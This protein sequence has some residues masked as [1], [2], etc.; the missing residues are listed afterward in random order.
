M[1]S[2]LFR[3][4]C[5]ERPLVSLQVLKGIQTVFFAVVLLLANIL[6]IGSLVTDL[7]IFG[8]SPY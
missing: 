3:K 4:L 6:S 5:L 8:L 2:T 7:S 1:V